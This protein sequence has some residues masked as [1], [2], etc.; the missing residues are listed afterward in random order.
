MRTSEAGGKSDR[1]SHE[2]NYK[3]TSA[4][5]PKRASLLHLIA[6]RAGRYLGNAD[7]HFNH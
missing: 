7:R 2:S 6:T 1:K 4:V 5:A 3:S